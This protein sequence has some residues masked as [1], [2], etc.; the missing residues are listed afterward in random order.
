MPEQTQPDGLWLVLRDFAGEI[1]RE[2]ATDGQDA[3]RV[4]I[5]MLARLTSLKDGDN[6]RVSRTP[7]QGPKLIEF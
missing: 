6:L 2:H 3:I 7:D 5:L 1:A 4:G